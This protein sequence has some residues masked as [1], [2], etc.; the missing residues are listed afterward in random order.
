MHCGDWTLVSIGHSTCAFSKTA[1][2]VTRSFCVWAYAIVRTESENNVAPLL[3]G[4]DVLCV[5]AFSR[6]LEDRSMAMDKAGG[7]INMYLAWRAK[8]KVV[9]K[10]RTI[11]YC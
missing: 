8:G 4:L 1:R 5:W 6:K 10:F 9:S 3:Y 11:P 2:T 7:L